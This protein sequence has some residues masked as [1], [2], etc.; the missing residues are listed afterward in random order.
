MLAGPSLYRD[1]VATAAGRLEISPQCGA[2]Y[3]QKE[4]NRMSGLITGLVLL[5]LGALAAASSIVARRPDAKAY[6]ELM[7][8]YQGWF[9]FITC[10]WGAWIIINAIIN[11]N[12]FGYVPVWWLTYLATGVLIASLG[13]LLGYALLTKLIFSHNAS[14][15]QRGEQIRAAIVPYQTVLGYAAIV[16]GLWT[17]VATFLYRI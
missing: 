14:A 17:I 5:A 15:A 6:I 16:L 7:V 3:C 13:L 8:P 1:V 2:K 12:W 11:L 9:G 4:R 10:L